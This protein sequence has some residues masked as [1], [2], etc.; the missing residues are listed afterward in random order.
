MPFSEAIADLLPDNESSLRDAD[1]IPK[2]L[3]PSRNILLDPTTDRN[4]TRTTANFCHREGMGRPTYR[5]W[6]DY[7][8]GELGTLGTM[9]AWPQPK[10]RRLRA[11]T[12]PFRFTYGEDFSIQ[13]FQDSDSEYSDGDEIPDRIPGDWWMTV[14]IPAIWSLIERHISNYGI[15]GVPYEP[16]KFMWSDPVVSGIGLGH[17]DPQERLFLA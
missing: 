5:D 14:A 7:R 1:E 17:L 6:I 15:N 4:H 12:D 3:D 13:D 9:Q 16:G 2:F 8:E 10:G 11:N